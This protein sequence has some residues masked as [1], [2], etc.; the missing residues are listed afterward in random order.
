MLKALRK[1]SS[2]AAVLRAKN[3]KP[4]A[5]FEV[6]AKA[7]TQCSADTPVRADACVR[8]MLRSQMPAARSSASYQKVL[9]P[10]LLLESC[11]A[12]RVESQQP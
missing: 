1:R 10:V 8:S 7:N 5:E 11:L 3:E 9:L 6:E 2:C 4:G 12:R